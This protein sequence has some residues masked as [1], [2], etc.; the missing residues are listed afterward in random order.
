MPCMISERLVV[1]LNPNTNNMLNPNQKL[2][3]KLWDKDIEQVPIRNGFGQGLLEAGEKNPNVVGLCAD[4]T[5]S[6]TMNLFRDKFPERFIEIGVAEQNLASVASGLSAMGKIPFITSYAMFSPGRNWEQIRTTICYNNR[7]VIIAGSHAG[8]SVGPDGGTHQ[9]IEDIAITRVIPR[10]VVISPCDHIEARKATLASLDLG[11]TVYIRLA[12]EKTPVIT[13]TDTPFE[14]GKAH[15]YY[16]ETDAKAD[17]GIVAT[18]ALLYRALK[19]AEALKNE[20]ISVKVLNISTIKPI[21]TDA[22]VGLAKTTGAIVTVEEHQIAGGLGSAVSEVLS[23]NFP[24]PQE[25]IG[26]SD[27]FGQSGTP[28]ELLEHY[29][30]GES[31][32]LAA[33]KKVIGRKN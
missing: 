17:V 24:V 12:R 30:M 18:G 22:V 9:A 23:Q 2:N 16:G 1:K 8:I 15:L 11:Q 6:T 19:V 14:I 27:K 21:D 3:P 4:L 20:N 25:F 5:I 7:V 26:V 33:A 29:G 13:T 28:D 31:H 32:I 10:M